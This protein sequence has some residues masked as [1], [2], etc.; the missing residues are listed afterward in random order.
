MVDT[1]VQAVESKHCAMCSSPGGFNT[2]GCDYLLSLVIAE[3]VA[4][5]M[6]ANDQVHD[7]FIDVLT[8]PSCR[9]VPQEFWEDFETARGRSHSKLS[10][11]CQCS[12]LFLF[13]E[14]GIAET[15]AQTSEW[16]CEQVMK[17]S[18]PRVDGRSAQN[19][20]RCCSTCANW[21]VADDI[22]DEHIIETILVPFSSSATG[23]AECLLDNWSAVAPEHSTRLDQRHRW[24]AHVWR[25]NE[26]HRSWLALHHDLRHRWVC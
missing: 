12:R 13:H 20:W 16:L 9:P 21:L 25:M 11:M 2:V 10:S 6:V 8:K 23:A 26:C 19:P 18:S 17:A 5:S 22:I 7:Q 15:V 4:S 1:A 14:Q 3:A 24:W